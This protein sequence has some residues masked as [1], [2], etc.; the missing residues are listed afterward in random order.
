MNWCERYV[1]WSSQGTYLA[2]FHNK[3]IALWGDAAFSKQG[4]FAHD[5]V[6]KLEFSPREPAINVYGRGGEFAPHQDHQALTVLVPLSPPSAAR[7][8]AE[9]P[10]SL[11]ATAEFRATMATRSVA[12][13]DES[14]RP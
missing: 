13:V 4:R 10:A 11:S 14:P 1:S 12:M 7:S 9:R 2:T 3:G 8:T 6:N 5:G